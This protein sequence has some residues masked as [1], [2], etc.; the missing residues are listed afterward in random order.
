MTKSIL[1]DDPHLPRERPSPYRQLSDRLAEVGQP[2]VGPNATGEVV[3]DLLFELMQA[4][5][6]SALD[7][8][9]WDELRQVERRLVVDFLMYEVPITDLAAALAQLAAIEMPVAP[10]DHRALAVLPPD[11]ARIVMPGAVDG[12]PEPGPVPA[13]GTVP[14]QLDIGP[15]EVDVF[16]VLE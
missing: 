15:L 2:P 5:G 7:R 10:P 1:L 9:A 6:V 12:G 14:L 13:A 11:L 16:K 3:N 8:A 4:G